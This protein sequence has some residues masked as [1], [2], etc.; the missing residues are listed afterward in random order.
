MKEEMQMIEK[1]KTWS[2]VQRPTDKNVVSV[3]WIYRLKTDSNG[4][5]VRHKARLVARGFAQQYGV[6]YL[7]TF[8][9]VSRHETIRLLLAVAAQRKWKL[10]QLDV[11]SA[12]LNGELEEEIYVEQPLGFEEK[13][14]E[15]HVLHLHKALY[16]LKQ[17]PRA[18]YNRIDE[19]FRRENFKRSDNDHA[20]YT[21]E[22]DG[23]LLVVCIYVDDLIVTG[24]DENMV[25]EF[26]ATMKEEFEMSD[27]GQL[28]YFLGMEIEQSQG[29]IRLSQEYYAKK[30][31]KKFNMEDCKSMNTPLI[32]QRHEQEED[33]DAVDPTLYR[34]LVGGLLYLIATRPD[35]M[36]SASYLS[37]YLKEPMSKHLKE[38]K[39]V[40]RY[41][42]GTSALGLKF[43]A[44][45]GSKLIGYSDSDWGGCR[46]DLKSTTGYCFSIGSAVFSWQTSK[47]DTIAQSTAEYM[48][49]CATENQAIWLRRLLEDIRFCSEEGVPIYCDNQSAI[50]IGKNPVQCTK[51]PSTCKSSII[52]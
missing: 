4:I 17:A 16:G 19:F 1:N 30:L 41:I 18:W 25:E 12:F 40:L 39:R 48:A 33:N 15:D 14:K 6:D 3:K 29:E 7:E 26:K 45:C 52:R 32:P 44:T 46:E 47:Q 24:D 5:V 34:S 21:K 13:G 10:F 42:K 31:L 27:L 49:L 20:L 35:L 2:L 37:R 28:N 50:A 51:G 22:T 9:P 8:A 43:T 36:F 23:K 38:A 11:K